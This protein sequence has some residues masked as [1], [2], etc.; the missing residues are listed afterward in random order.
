[1]RDRCEPFLDSLNRYLDGELGAEA[2]KKMQEHLRSCPRCRRAHVEAVT[3][4][5]LLRDG[6]RAETEDEAQDAEATARLLAR[7]RQEPEPEW[8]RRKGAGSATGWRAWGWFRGRGGSRRL[9]PALGWAGGLAAATAAVLLAIRLGMPESPVEAQRPREEKIAQAP[10][11][12]DLEQI[13]GGPGSMGSDRPQTAPPVAAEGAAP[14]AERFSLKTPAPSAGSPAPRTEADAAKAAHEAPA[15]AQEDAKENAEGEEG[16]FVGAVRPAPVDDAALSTDTPEPAPADEEA[17]T[18]ATNQSAKK[19]KAEAED[20]SSVP[21]TRGGK[22]TAP[23]EAWGRI[24]SLADAPSAS[25]PDLAVRADL[26]DSSEVGIFSAVDTLTET[27]DL[28]S[29]LERGSRALEALTDSDLDRAERARR[30][31]VIG[32][33]WEWLGRRD[34]SA[35]FFTRAA[36]AY[37]TAV[38]VDPQAG[39]SDS[40][41]VARARAGAGLPPDA[42]QSGNKAPARR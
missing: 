7:L 25:S 29:R 14:S 30:W 40:V 41:R 26:V 12:R 24:R 15:Q 28:P 42:P 16:T 34:A 32:D 20:R 9:G 8:A 37:E 4:D 36:E 39:A 5:R 22:G 38:L 17:R 3:A 1:M 27:V 6:L 35:A 33:L 18:A 31:R 10:A 13:P 19:E 11:E 21:H 23:T 2:A